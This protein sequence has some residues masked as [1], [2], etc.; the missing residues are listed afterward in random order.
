MKNRIAQYGFQ[1][2]VALVGLFFAIP[3]SAQIQMSAGNYAQNFD[4]LATSGTANSWADNVTLLGWYASKSIGGATISIYR[5]DNGNT[6]ALYSYGVAGVNSVADRALGSTSSGTPGT[7]AYGVRLTNDTAIT[8][9]NLSITYTGEQWRNGGNTSPQTLSF[10]YRVSSIPIVNSDA[11]NANSWV[12]IPS[13]DFATPTVG[14]SSTVVDGNAATN[15]Q[16]FTTVLITGV[17]VQPSQEIFLRWSD[18][19]DAGNDHGFG[20]DDL[21]ITFNAGSNAPPSAPS[22]TTQPQ[23]QSATIGDNVA[24]TVVV[25]GSATLS[26]QWK[27]FGTNLP[28]ATNATLTLNSVST[29]H[30]G[31]YFVTVTNAL[32]STNSQ[33][34]TL[35]VIPP[36]AAVAGFSLMNYNTHG[37]FISD[38]TTNS[39]QIQAIGRQVQYLN[40]DI[41]TFQEIPMTNS[42]WSHMG[43]FT[44]VYRPGYYLATNS[45]TDGF[46]RSAILSR[47][48]ITRSTSW[49]DGADLNPY[50]YT[51]ADFTRDLFEAVIAVPGFP[52]P[53][54]V[55]T[56]HLKSGQ[57]TAE[58][59]RRG[60]ESLAISNFF[61]QIFL[62]T[63]SLHTYLLT[64]DMNEDL[65]RPPTPTNPH[66]ID[67]LTS[68][69]TGL[70]LTTPTNLYTGSDMTFS[71]QAAS[72]TKRYDYILP[73]GLLFS[74][75]ASSQIF[76]SD[77][78]P[79][80]PPPLLATDSETASDHMPVRMSFNNPYDKPFKLLSVTRTN[81]AV[82][83]KWES[84]PGQ[85]Y[86]VES[87]TNLSEWSTLANNLVATGANYTFA[88]NLNDVARYFRI[89]RLP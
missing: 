56:V 54:H 63:N 28:N 11:A 19:N 4:S 83:L 22:I 26:Y 36:I 37:N 23:N 85:P 21:T 32:G 58:S 67:T 10:S 7:I 49:L 12:S 33:T 68:P 6:G 9:T 38:W 14:A 78:L 65:N 89:Y 41:I 29:N 57:A 73:C 71:I 43:E 40:P 81:L 2:V 42:G 46:I 70:K 30:A 27:F 87:S 86:R 17:S 79:S 80:P 66:S 74:N 62:S 1:V 64:G 47:Y 34:A 44:A 35:T 31:N 75:I 76:R 72:T 84:V 45:G 82:T 20:V 48:P 59:N 60:A 53:V 39:L 55:F 16:V 77:L 61:S 50:G 15:R 18:I 52:Q 13:L 8:F 5:S 88:T 3:M 24:F 25:S 51:N 69:P